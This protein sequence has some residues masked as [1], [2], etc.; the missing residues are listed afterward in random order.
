[1]PYLFVTLLLWLWQLQSLNQI[2]LNNRAR[3]EAE[4]AYASG[5]FGRAAEQ[6]AYVVTHAPTVDPTVRLNLGH[7]YFRLGQAAK[8][9]QQYTLLLQ[10]GD[11]P[12]GATAAVQLGVLACAEQDSAGAL[13]YFRQALWQDPDNEPARYNFE[14]LE[15]TFTGK[16]APANR[17]ATGQAQ[18]RATSAPDQQLPRPAPDR[19]VERSARQDERLNRFRSLNMTEA[20]A[21]QLLNTMQH[22]DVPYPVAQRQAKGRKQRGGDRANRW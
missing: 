19:Q 10:A 20:Q 1:M 7:A 21:L 22:N 13:R 18:P 5:D 4:A 6:Y 14:L 17:R 9:R 3:K 11:H 2:S 15:R 8:A 12:F 16:Q